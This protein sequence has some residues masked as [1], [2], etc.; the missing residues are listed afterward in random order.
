MSAAFCHE[1]GAKLLPEAKFCSKCGADI[2]AEQPVV[3]PAQIQTC[4]FCAKCGSPLLIGAVCCSKCGADVAQPAAPTAVPTQQQ[5][6]QLQNAASRLTEL[7]NA[8]TGQG[9]FPAGISE[10]GSE[11]V[12][13]AAGGS[14]SGA[15]WRRLLRA[16]RPLRRYG[17]RKAL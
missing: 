17:T 10:L 11:A 5:L 6:S 4:G 7:T 3:Q 12:Q 9:E 16:A 14:V 1:C 13:A 15:S 8:P 2:P